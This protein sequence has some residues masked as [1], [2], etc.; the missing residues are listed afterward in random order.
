M[1]P[2]P[3]CPPSQLIRGCLYVLLNVSAAVLIEPE[4]FTMVRTDRP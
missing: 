1:T 2:P 4:S 3:L